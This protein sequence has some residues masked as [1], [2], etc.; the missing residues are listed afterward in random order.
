MKN[1]KR[2]KKANRH[3]TNG[4]RSVD[5][6]VGYGGSCRLGHSTTLH[7]NASLQKHSVSPGIATQALIRA[8]IT[9]LT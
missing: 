2:L 5:R 3:I 6:S 8:G 7:S 1:I 4:I 9:S